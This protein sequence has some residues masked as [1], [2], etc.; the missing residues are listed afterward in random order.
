MKKLIITDLDGTFVFDSIKVS[1]LDLKKFKEF[2]KNNKIAVATGRSIKEIEYIEKENNIKFDYKIGF[3]GSVIEDIN[4]KVIF[5]KKLDH[6]N[7][8]EIYKYLKEKNLIFDA[9][10]GE[11]RI[12]NFLHEKPK[13]L[14]N[15][16]MICVEN[17]YE[18]LKNKDIFKINIRP[19]KD[20]S[21]KIFLELL[22]KFPNLSIVKTSSSRIEVCSE[23]ISKGNAIIFI[24]NIEQFY[25]VGIGDSENDRSM[26]E[27]V[28]KAICMEHSPETIKNIADMVVKNIY[29]IDKI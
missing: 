14:W 29:M 7:L 4:G 25:T 6:N 27:I 21:D 19:K 9:L 20:E 17:P 1:E 28:D 3:N 5:E 16:D 8:K 12:G 26:L 23:N 22:N 18:L 15:M 13:H 2:Q 24:N 10:D 11:K